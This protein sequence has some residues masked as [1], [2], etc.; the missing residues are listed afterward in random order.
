MSLLTDEE[1]TTHELPYPVEPGCYDITGLC[2]AQRA[3]TL[4]AVA[5]HLNRSCA[6]RS[7][8][9]YMDAITDC[10]RCMMDTVAALRE[11]KMPGEEK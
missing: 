11:G 7:H 9:H 8:R 10:P 3:K 6:V 2:Q 4:K 5:G 1:I